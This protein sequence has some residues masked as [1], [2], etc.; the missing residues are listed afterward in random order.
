MNFF[1]QI[2]FYDNLGLSA[3]LDKTNKLKSTKNEPLPLDLKFP[4]VSLTRPFYRQYVTYNGSLTTPPCN[5]V[6]VWILSPYTL[7]ISRQQ[8]NQFRDIASANGYVN[9]FRNIQSTN[10]RNVVYVL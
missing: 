7:H 6:V 3:I 9:N 1:P 10:N 2:S 4:L 5:E 8:L